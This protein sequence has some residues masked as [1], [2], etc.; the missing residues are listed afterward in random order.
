M[1]QSNRNKV[2]EYKQKVDAGKFSGETN[3]EDNRHHDKN[4]ST[5]A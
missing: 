3:E 4:T 2:H 1:L 5:K